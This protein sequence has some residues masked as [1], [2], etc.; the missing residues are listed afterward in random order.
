MLLI[1]VDAHSKWIE[2]L[3]MRQATSQSTITAPRLLFATHGIP[4]VLVS[5]NGTCF[6]SA[7][8]T[9]FCEMN[10]I[11]HLRIPPRH[12][13]SNGLAERVVQTVKEGLRKQQGSDIHC[14]LAKFLLSYRT[15][16]QST[17]GVT[18]AELLMKR[19]LRTRLDLL[20]ISLSSTVE[21]KQEK[22]PGVDRRERVFQPG[23]NVYV[24]NYGQ[25]D[26]WLPGAVVDKR[27]STSMGVQCDR[28]IVYVHA[29]Q[30]RARRITPDIPM[31]NDGV[32][33][34][35]DIYVPPA[36]PT[37]AA[38]PPTQSPRDQ[39]QQTV[40]LRRSTREKKPVDRLTL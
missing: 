16:P 35:D 7:E 37:V 24:R 36:T 22:W 2:A 23:D 14:R 21:A 31:S 19:R 38:L 25:G 1:V 29:D 10:K 5:D 6:T 9:T 13:A 33:V 4:E 17:T 8:F 40:P 34:D 12:P 26:A 30:A 27:S 28:G 20:R 39:G 3:P 18:P 11:R 15:T 32:S